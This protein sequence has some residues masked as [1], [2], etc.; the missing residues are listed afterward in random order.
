M[1]TDT[2]HEDDHDHEFLPTVRLTRRRALGAITG[3]L[4]AVLLAACGSSS[5]SGSAGSATTAAGSSSSAGGTSATTAAS[6]PTS[7]AGA[8]TAASSATT[9][10]A[11]SASTSAASAAATAIEWLTPPTET[12]GPF[13]ADGSNSNGAGGTANVLD[14]ATA[15]RTDMT[16]DLDGAN[17][18]DG[19]PMNLS[20]TIGKKA[21]KSA[22][23]GAA[24]YVWHCNATGHYSQY[25]GGMN[26]GDFSAN[27]F[28]RAVGV[29]DAEGKVSFTS[30]MPGRYQGRATHVHFAV[31]TDKTLSK[32]LLTSQFAFDDTESDAIYKAHSAYSASLDNPTYNKSD[33]VFHDG[34]SNQLLDLSGTAS[35]DA[36]I[37]ILVG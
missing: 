2:L 32:R 30:I 9:A 18:Q 8:T 1:N 29:A 12:G 23:E 10:A 22:Y 19:F 37:H 6:S 21:D 20:V 26:G 17:K 16:G 31:F 7:A 35:V 14:K 15:F 33:N 28:L 25:S 13:P 5:S 11:A 34:V 24:V 36:A 27:S 4:G 3:G